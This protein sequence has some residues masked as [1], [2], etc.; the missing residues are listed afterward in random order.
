MEERPLLAAIDMPNYIATNPFRQ[1]AVT[2]AIYDSERREQG[3]GLVATFCLR[4]GRGARGGASSLRM[5]WLA[6]VG[7]LAGWLASKILNCNEYPRLAA[8]APLPAAQNS[9]PTHSCLPPPAENKGSKY[10][11]RAEYDRLAALLASVPTSEAEDQALLD[12]GSV[13]GTCA[14]VFSSSCPLQYC[15][16]WRWCCCS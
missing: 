1:T 4:G 5:S 14:V 12:G 9:H 6:A 3:L 10:V 15:M 16:C 2:D 8:L 13:T 11:N 7:G